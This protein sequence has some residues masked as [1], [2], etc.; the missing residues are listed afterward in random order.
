MSQS[1][2]TF[3][4][5]PEVASAQASSEGAAFRVLAGSTAMRAGAS[6][7]KR[8]RILRDKLVDQGVLVPD[9]NSVLYR[10]SK[11]YTFTS[12]SQAGGVIKDGNCS[13]PGAWTHSETGET[14]RDWLNRTSQ[15]P[16]QK[17]PDI[18]T[19]PYKFPP[20]PTEGNP[21]GKGF[22]KPSAKFLRERLKPGDLRERAASRTPRTL[23]F[24][25]QLATLF[26][27]V[28]GPVPYIFLDG[29]G[30]YRRLDAGC[31]GFLHHGTPQEI[32]FQFDDEGF[33]AA[34]LPVAGTAL[35]SDP[36]PL[37]FDLSKKPG[38]GLK[39]SSRRTI[40]EGASAFRAKMIVQWRGKCAVTGTS[41]IDAL[42]AAHIYP[43]CDADTNHPRNGLLLRADIHRLFDRHMIAFEYAGA[44]LVC[45]VSE[46]LTD[47][48]YRSL[49]GAEIDL[50]A[51]KRRH[52]HPALIDHQM[53]KFRKQETLNA[54]SSTK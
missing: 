18:I 47:D 50:P 24:R 20:S 28:G 32:G 8:D 30:L 13:G 41:E 29:E 23:Y 36:G 42:D 33:I 46:R 15:K 5:S 51:D 31:L 1:S 26:Q 11:D 22:A 38:E 4:F 44:A 16:R 9:T 25:D 6:S 12:A 34:A 43:Y 14:L 39:Q 37:N 40:R 52:P 10:F 45:R 27:I 54:A 19:I 35:D 21:F 53:Q 3:V 48:G 49:A 7:V 17:H 2:T